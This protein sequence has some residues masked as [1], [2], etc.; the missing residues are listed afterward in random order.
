MTNGKEP[1]DI[2]SQNNNR[3]EN[4]A[5]VKRQAQSQQLIKIKTENYLNVIDSLAKDLKGED[6]IDYKISEISK[7][8]FE[9]DG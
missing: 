3:S 7:L 2:I 4:T 5:L 1:K 9:R 6:E 8:K